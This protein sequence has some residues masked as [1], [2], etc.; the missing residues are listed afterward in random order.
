MKTTRNLRA[1]RED[2]GLS[3]LTKAKVR[4]ADGMLR[5]EEHEDK[6]EAAVRTIEECFPGAG[7]SAIESALKQKGGVELGT[8][9]QS[10][11]FSPHNL[12]CAI[13]LPHASPRS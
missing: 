12:C 2:V 3:S 13:A 5:E 9:P 6:F 8:S 4:G 1:G 10:Q 11:C 7:R